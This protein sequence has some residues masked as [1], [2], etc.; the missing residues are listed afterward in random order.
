MNNKLDRETI[1]AMLRTDFLFHRSKYLQAKRFTASE[2]NMIDN[3]LRLFE[4]GV[5]TVSLYN[6]KIAE[7][8]K[9]F[10]CIVAKGIFNADLQC[11]ILTIKIR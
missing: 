5:K 2:V 3:I 9:D 10:D 7:Y 6:E 1:L 8:F 11:H 4:K